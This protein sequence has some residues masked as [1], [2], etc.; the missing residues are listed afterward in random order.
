MA[1]LGTRVLL[2][3]PLQANLSM[4]RPVNVSPTG[5]DGGE[6]SRL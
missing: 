5:E 2:S 6:V 4:Y 3:E 1:A